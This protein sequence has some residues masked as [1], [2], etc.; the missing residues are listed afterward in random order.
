M[1]RAVEDLD[2]PEVVQDKFVRPRDC[3]AVWVNRDQLIADFDLRTEG[4]AGRGDDIDLWLLDQATRI[5]VAQ[6]LNEVANTTICFDD[7]ESVG[8]RLPF[9]GRAAVLPVSVPK[10][11]RRHHSQ[12]VSSGLIDVKG[13][14]VANGNM[15]TDDRKRNGLLPLRRALRE[16]MTQ[17]MVEGIFASAGLSIRG[18][19]VYAILRLGFDVRVGPGLVEPAALLLRR[20]HQRPPGNIELPRFGDDVHKAQMFVELFL[21][22]HGVSSSA[23]NSGLVIEADDNQAFHIKVLGVKQSVPEFRMRQLL[24]SITDKDSVSCGFI[25][26]QTTRRVNYAALDIEL[27]DFGQ[28]VA[29]IKRF[30]RPFMSAV[31]NLPLNFGCVFRPGE[32]GWVQPSHKYSVNF[33]QLAEVRI[34]PQTR[35]RLRLSADEK[36]DGLNYAAASMAM[37]VSGGRANRDSINRAI[38][39][40]V[41]RALLNVTG[42]MSVH[43]LR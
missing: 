21:R 8:Y 34:E 2:E 11:L 30:D 6:T 26:V 28:Y 13:C 18:V 9:Y 4:N 27:V 40:F 35:H 10:H 14:G 7:C 39:D 32:P 23:F 22:Q 33:E 36:I 15:P 37:D 19:P 42:E 38:N 20:A 5:S 12:G 29:G 24:R 31:I 16:V 43:Q 41:A 1:P 25:N 17:R 3:A